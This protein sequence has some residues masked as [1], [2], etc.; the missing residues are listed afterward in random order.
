MTE[1]FSISRVIVEYFNWITVILFSILLSEGKINKY[2]LSKYNYLQIVF[3]RIIQFYQFM[4]IKNPLVLFLG[5]TSMVSYFSYIIYK[6]S[7]ESLAWVLGIQFFINISFYPTQWILQILNLAD[8]KHIA[9]FATYYGV[10]NTIINLVI[11]F[12]L[13]RKKSTYFLNSFQ[14]YYRKYILVLNLF[15]IIIYFQNVWSLFQTDNYS[16][17]LLFEFQKNYLRSA[18]LIIILVILAIILYK[19]N[20]EIESQKNLLEEYAISVDNL[21]NDIRTYKHDI[22]NI[23]LSLKYTI[24]NNN[25]KE[26]K[27]YFSKNIENLHGLDLDD[28]KTIS[29]ISNI[30][31]KAL[32]GLILSK[33][34]KSTELGIDFEISMIS[35]DI[36][37]TNVVDIDLCR[38]IGIILDNAIEA[39][40][41]L[42]SKRIIIETE[43]TGPSWKL[44][45]SNTFSLD[46]IH[47]DLSST[48]SCNR[49][50]GLKSLKMLVKKYNFVSLNTTFDSEYFSQE[51]L[52]KN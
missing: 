12:L 50:I 37:S 46:K 18:I 39:N 29:K 41:H 14:K 42:S 52:F 24:D 44:K 2:S 45:I 36:F 9:T 17:L 49:G 51:L 43:K 19:K 25:I 8:V 23:L 30:H 31:S 33:Y 5:Y 32:K 27:S 21:Y 7:N 15:F 13:S 38:M 35:F 20:R 22:N 28:Y 4:F 10:I 40:E 34:H 6:R 16:K 48:K 11:I 1:L 26:I 3:L 47:N